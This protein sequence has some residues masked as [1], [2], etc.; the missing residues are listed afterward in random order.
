MNGID[1]SKHKN[2]V[3]SMD[4]A[5][6]EELIKRTFRLTGIILVGLLLGFVVMILI[7]PHTNPIL[8]VSS[9]YSKATKS[10][11]YVYDYDNI[12]IE[13]LISTSGICTLDINN[14]S[15]GVFYGNRDSNQTQ[16]KAVMYTSPSDLC[17]STI[18]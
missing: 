16:I 10:Y 8:P 4:N 18:T 6:K 5:L 14:V 7:Y 9:S 1:R 15:Y 17:N 12:S 3:E 2:K 11:T 13:Y